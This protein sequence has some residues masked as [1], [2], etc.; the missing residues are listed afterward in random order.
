MEYN[1]LINMP[2]FSDIEDDINDD[3]TEP[4]EK[5][6]NHVKPK[7]ISINFTCNV[8]RRYRC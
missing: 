8:R 4:Q 5:A 1:V 7:T 3:D 2:D 6:N